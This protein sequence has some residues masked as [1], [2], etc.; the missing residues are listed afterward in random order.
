MFESYQPRGTTKLAECLDVAMEKYAGK[1]RQDF[2]VVPGTTFLIILDGTTDDNE[3]VKTLLHRY[4]DPSNGYIENHTQIAMSFIQIG[5]DF[6]ATAFL[7]EM[8]EGAPGYPDICDTKKDNELF[9]KGGVDK[10]LMDAIFD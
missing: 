9:A 10:V 5:D 6:H 8:D 1:H 7:K 3:A 4:A 2:A